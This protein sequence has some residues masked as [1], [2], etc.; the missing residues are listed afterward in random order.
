MRDARQFDHRG[1]IGRVQ[2]ELPD[3]A[4]VEL[5]KVLE[6]QTGE[7]LM[8]GELLRAE[9]MRV[10][11]ERFARQRVGDLQHLP[12]RLAGLHPSLF[13][14]NRTGAPYLTSVRWFSTEQDHPLISPIPLF[15]PLISPPLI[16]RTSPYSPL[17]RRVS[18]LPRT[19]RRNRR[20]CGCVARSRRRTSFASSGDFAAGFPFAVRRANRS[21]HVVP[22]ETR[23]SWPGAFG[24]S[25]VPADMATNPGAP[26]QPCHCMRLRLGR[27]ATIPAPPVAIQKTGGA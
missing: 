20:R 13:T 21:K 19:P 2:Q 12:W 5:E 17:I 7:E 6:R 15:R 9:L 1:Q 14:H 26:G 23:G 3:A 10:R 8:L 24:D 16:R 4:I 22:R 27:P 25:P 11:R 18:T